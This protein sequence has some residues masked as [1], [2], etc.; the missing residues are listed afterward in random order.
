[1]GFFGAGL[2][3][4]M[5]MLAA[6]RG[7]GAIDMGGIHAAGNA[8]YLA[9]LLAAGGLLVLS[10]EMPALRAYQLIFL[11]FT[12]LYLLM[13]LPDIAAMAG[14]RVPRPIIDN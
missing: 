2:A 9:G 13:N 11:I 4:S 7:R 5:Y 12:T 1:M 8:G 3:P 10:D 6:R 14:W